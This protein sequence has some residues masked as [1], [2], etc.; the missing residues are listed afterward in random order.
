MSLPLRQRATLPLRQSV[1][2]FT[3]CHV[4]IVNL[5]LVRLEVVHPSRVLANIRAGPAVGAGIGRNGRRKGLVQ[6]KIQRLL[7]LLDVSLAIAALRRVK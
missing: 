2:S 3:F 4:R 1:Y 5:V 7:P 6:R